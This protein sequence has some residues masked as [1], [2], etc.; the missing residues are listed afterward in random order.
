MSEP[1]A[2]IT[3]HRRRLIDHRA[4]ETSAVSRVFRLEAADG[5]VDIG[6]GTGIVPQ[7]VRVHDN[8]RLA[9]TIQ[10][11]IHRRGVVPRRAVIPSPH[12]IGGG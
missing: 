11:I 9:A 6:T 5:R 3:Y 1:L 2:P 8:A 10:A 7:V 4:T 12:P